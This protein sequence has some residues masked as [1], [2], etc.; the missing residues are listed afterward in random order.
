MRTSIT[1]Q[2]TAA[3]R[4]QVV[5]SF[6]THS[7]SQ[8]DLLSLFYYSVDNRSSTS[9]PHPPWISSTVAL[10]RFT[11]VLQ[12]RLR[13]IGRSFSG[14]HTSHTTL[15]HEFI[16]HLVWSFLALNDKVMLCST[17][18]VLGAYARLRYYASSLPLS[19][20]DYLHS[21]G[22]ITDV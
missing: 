11:G 8:V 10:P 16:I 19:H 4:P 22:P 7:S 15:P 5:Y 18:R 3:I 14:L 13:G 12:R 1:P 17:Y 6:N 2:H 9:I 21:I 20:W